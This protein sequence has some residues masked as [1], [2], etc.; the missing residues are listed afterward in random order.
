MINPS[1]SAGR[2]EE[3]EE[4]EEE[5]DDD[6]MTDTRCKAAAAGLY[7]GTV[8]PHTGGFGLSVLQR[9]GQSGE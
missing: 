1:Q 5:D 2:K 8:S 3:K 9:A 7:I 4:D 6:L